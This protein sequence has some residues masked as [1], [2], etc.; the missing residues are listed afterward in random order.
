MKANAVQELHQ[1]MDA[2]VAI[3]MDLECDPQLDDEALVLS[4]VKARDACDAIKIASESL[5]DLA[6][7]LGHDNIVNGRPH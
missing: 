1:V 6:G 3:K 7:E 2:L 4:A 5:R